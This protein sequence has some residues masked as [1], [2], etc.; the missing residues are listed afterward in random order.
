MAK[1]PRQKPGQSVQAVGTPEVFLQAVYRRLGITEF[2]YDLAGD[3]V[4][5]VCPLYI[6]EAQDS[7][8]IPWADLSADWM[9][10]NPPYARL[11]PWMQHAYEQSLDGAKVAILIPASTGSNYWKRYVDGKAYVLLL[12]GRITFVGHKIAYPKDC[13]LLLYGPYIA[14]GYEVWSWKQ[15]VQ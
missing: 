12:N 9:W 11:G 4:R 8:S 5:H 3:A 14:P 15:E 1:M 2:A 6:T 13:V 7:L 10:L